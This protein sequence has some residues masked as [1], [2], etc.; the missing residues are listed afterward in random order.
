[1]SAISSEE[2]RIIRDFIGIETTS[3]V[4]NLALIEQVANRL[5]GTAARVEIDYNADRTKANLIAFIGPD[6]PGGV[7]L[8]GHTDTVPVDGQDWDTNPFQ[9]EEIG[10]KIYGRGTCDMKSF[11]ALSVARFESLARGGHDGLKKP[12]GLFLTFDEEL[13]CDGAKQM[14]ETVFPRMPKPDLVLVGEPTCL[15]PAHAHKGVRCFTTHIK[16]H[17]CHSSAPDKGVNAVR[18]SADLIQYLYVLSAALKDEGIKDFRFDPPQT[19][20]N[21]GTVSGGS[22][23]NVVADEC[24]FT[25]DL[26]PVPGQTGDDIIEAF[27]HRAEILEHTFRAVSSLCHIRIKEWGAIPAFAG[28]AAHP[29]T[30]L[31][32]KLLPNRELIVVPF[33]TEAGIFGAAGWNCIVCGPGS[34]E[35]AHQPNEF[36]TVEQIN[37]CSRLLTDLTRACF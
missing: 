32:L 14:V 18:L 25:F 17:G 35:Q 19:T 12:L 9:A 1:M 34:I 27:H 8:S 24:V 26:R 4:S 30:Q 13:G 29:G 15:C 37:E 23:V 11:C 3:R 28:D 6:A 7:I 2:T 31:L 22:A 33:G 5:D 20:L 10:G 36:I 16:G 21:V